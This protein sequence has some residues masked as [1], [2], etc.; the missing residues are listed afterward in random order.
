MASKMKPKS[1]AK[2]SNGGFGRPRGRQMST[3]NT[4]CVCSEKL[5]FFLIFEFGKKTAQNKK[6][7][8][9]AD[10]GIPKGGNAEWAE[11]PGAPFLRGVG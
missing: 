5:D 2:S 4:F 3:S 8:S 11:W 1:M 7:W 10:W 9:R 6:N